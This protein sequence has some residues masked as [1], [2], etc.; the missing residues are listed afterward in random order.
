MSLG[1]KIMK[2][3]SMKEKASKREEVKE[4][5]SVN[6]IKEIDDKYE[7]LFKIA[8]IIKKDHVIYKVKANGACA[9]N[10]TAIHCHQDETFGQEKCE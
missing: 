4:D 3:K 10:C 7:E 9:S 8:G 2:K 6:N 5:T 1:K